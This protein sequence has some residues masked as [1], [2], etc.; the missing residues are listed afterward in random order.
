MKKVLSILCT[1]ILFTATSSMA[2]PQ[3]LQ[4]IQNLAG[5]I[6]LAA[7]NSGA[8][9]A[10]LDLAKEKLREV[11]DLLN[12]SGNG[13]T[14]DPIS[15]GCFDFAYEK[16][17]VSQSTSTA[18][19][20]ALAACKKISDLEVAKFLYDKYFVASSAAT[21]MNEASNRS[22]PALSGKLDMLTFTYDKYFVAS[23][24]ATAANKAS[25]AIKTVPRG[26]LG[27][28]QKLYEKHF[29]S[30]SA[31]TAMDLAIKDCK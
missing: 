5:Q 6:H 13:N 14:P 24:A 15:G 2:T 30:K 17:F 8:T 29:T 23:S 31:A 9:D 10:E 27:C 11:I 3:D 28:L 7:K 25:D 19:T 12:Q 18:T 22:G 26:R 1:V 16:F 4:E 21:A 20:N